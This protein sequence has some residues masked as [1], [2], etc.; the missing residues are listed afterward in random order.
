MR[1]PYPD[2]VARPVPKRACRSAQNHFAEAAAGVAAGGRWTYEYV[3]SRESEVT[4]FR[5][6]V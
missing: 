3:Y 2:Q 1:K 5:P 4:F 6:Q